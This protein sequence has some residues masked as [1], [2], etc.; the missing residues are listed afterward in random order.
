VPDAVFEVRRLSDL[1]GDERR[2]RL[3]RSSD[4]IFDREVRAYARQVLEDVAR[5]GDAAVAAYTARWDRVAL[6]PGRFAV[7]DDE[8]AGAPARIDD[9]LLAALD[10][11]L[12][13]VRRVNEWLRPP[14]IRLKEIEPGITVGIR[15]QPVRSAGLY[16]PSGKGAFPST[17]IML[18]TPAVVAGV[19]RLAVVVP[20]GPDGTVD[21]AVL[22]VAGRLGIRHVYRCNGPAGVAALALGTERI[23]K[24]DVVGGPGSPVIAAVQRAA[25]AYGATP[26]TLMGPSEAIILADASADPRLLAADLLTEAEHGA[27]SAAT[28]ITT[29][30]AA[31]E[32]AV[33]AL[34]AF[35]DHLPEPRR[36]FALQ[37]VR[38]RG[39]VF[40]ATDLAEAVDW[41]NTYAPEHVLVA[42]ADPWEAVAR[43]RHAGEILIGHATPL[44]AANYAIGVTHALPTG[45]AAAAASGITVLAFLKAA[46]IAELTDAGLARVAPAARRIG[47]YEGFP[48]HV[49]AIAAREVARA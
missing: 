36:A 33:A 8:I 20:P 34:P 35:L 26:L 6:P 4:A 10:V 37:A 19:E 27:D 47:V 30:T 21:P 46:S 29:D 15:I 5:D 17:M 9:G 16:V 40:V 48:A 11:S 18:G 22:A 28:L 25:A 42:T 49:Q 41:I 44:S 3:A 31:A 32:Q 38:G 7:S 13:R 39:G 45:G 24:M 14:E 43:I 12:A 1:T 23:P 2:R